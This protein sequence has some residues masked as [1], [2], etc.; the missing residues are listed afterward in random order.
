MVF[1]GIQK[2]SLIDY[3]EKTACTLFTIG[4]NFNCPFC[5]NSSLI[6]PAGG[7]QVITTTEVLSFLETRKGLLD[8]VCIS[9]GEPLLQNEL[10]IFIKDVKDM[11]FLVKLDTNGN[12]PGKLKEMIE[13]GKID[14]IAMDIKNTPE[15]YAMTTGIPG[16]EASPVRESVDI[17]ISC[18]VPYEFRT[19]VVREFHNVEDLC[20]IAKWISGAR[21]YYL[22]GFRNSD[23]VLQS[24]INGYSNYEMQEFLNSIKSLI[25]TAELR[26]F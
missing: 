26:G 8:G 3:P 1:G 24:G 18:S 20:A 12:N 5:H 6:D 22:Q 11:G 4:C 17:L 25:P 15:K 21:K 13:T 7:G 14:Y 2:V 9:G 16:Y 10:E 19:T 23:G